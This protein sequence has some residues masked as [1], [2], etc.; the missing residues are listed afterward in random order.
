MGRMAA[1]AI[2]VDA[3]ERAH[4]PGWAAH[5]RTYAAPLLALAVA[6]P[7]TTYA[8]LRS[9]AWIDS[10][11][12]GFFVMA[13]G[14]VPT[15]SGYAWPPDKAALF[16][17]RVVA[18]DGV[19]VGSGAEI[20]RRVRAHRPGT[21]VEYRLEAIEGER[22]LTL[23]VLR[24][25]IRDYLQTHGILL[26][27]GVTLLTIGLVVGFLQP[28][29]T[30]ARV[31]LLH[32][33]VAG[34][35]AITAVFLHQSEFAFLG[36]LCLTAECFV[37]ATFVHL[38]MTFPVQRLRGGW[39]RGLI[40]A[41]Y[42]LS[43]LLA[44]EALHG[45]DDSPPRLTA[46]H[47]AYLY[48]A[49]GLVLLIASMAYAYWENHDSR[50]RPRIKAVVPGAVLAA[51]VQAFIFLNNALGSR[52]LP[53]QFGLLVP[54]PYFL[55]LAYAIAKHDLFDIDRV[56]RL[57]FVYVVLSVI[58]IAA[59]A[60]VLQLSTLLVPL[61]GGGSQTLAGILF[62]LL[63]AF[64]LDPLRRGVQNVVDRALYR[65]RLDYR[66]TISELSALMTTLL[67]L[68]EIA[69]QVTRVVADAMQLESTAIALADD[70]GGG[71]VWQRTADGAIGQTRHFG[72]GIVTRALE[73]QPRLFDAE[74][75]LRSLSSAER[76]EA[77]AFFASVGA[78]IV[79]PLLFRGRASGVL[80]LGAKRSGRPFDSEAIDLLR[81]LANQI[82]IA[83]ENARSYKALDD[84]NR[85]LDA[86][87]RQ[88]T[89]ELRA[90][91]EQLVRAYEELKSAQAQL[92]QSEKMASLG[93]LVAG[94]AHELNNPASFVAGGLANLAEYLSRFLQLIEAYER[95]PIAEATTAAEIA[96]LRQR[97]RFDY[98]LRETPELL[99]VCAEGSERIN[100]IVDDL[101][102]FAR[103]DGGMREP[104][105]LQEGIESSLRLLGARLNRPQLRLR[106]EYTEVPQVH[107]DAGQLNRVWTNLISNALDAV[108][109]C[110]RGE[111]AIA[112]RP[113][114]DDRGGAVEVE[115]R[116]NGPGIDPAHL[117]KIFEPFFSTKPIGKGTGLGLS[118]A[119]GA[120]KSHGGSIRVDSAPG[121]G[122][123]VIVT[124][125]V[126]VGTS[127]T[128]P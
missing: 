124:L 12:P 34:I 63:L 97:L 122:T 105:T 125:P 107:A 29:T 71:A 86:K 61:L 31:F 113:A 66:A 36:K 60:A 85:D 35:Y 24:F 93:Q 17:R 23:P 119:Y 37:S 2:V 78:R 6:A 13:N 4:R 84:L 83:V 101:R 14:V 21:L 1:D 87:V 67:D 108:E 33:F 20:Y 46:L 126:S 90:S 26:F 62:V 115:I 80:A 57:S 18:V 100:R 53:V 3:V 56:V 88:Q 112:I 51:G 109:T 54:T 96:H 104:T 10:N 121:R 41:A 38:A 48:T 117:G 45:F 106:R 70:K 55:G 73:R 89:E 43:G 68:Q 28:R 82:A 7:L 65:K 114:H 127:A 123:A 25:G 32:T 15:V 9:L 79:L 27:F 39:R 22:R 91:N 59:Y 44:L 111:I 103:A 16:H 120:V 58:V 98:L 47:L 52:D 75:L 128:I 30:Q 102:L 11:F 69:T 77:Q 81:T 50:V 5:L 92:V 99:R 110:E 42:G 64:A 40:G 8:A 94:V 74:A 49:A 118:I 76:A 19:E 72:V 95:A 116:D